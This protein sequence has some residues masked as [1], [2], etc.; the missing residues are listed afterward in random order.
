MPR[1]LLQPADCLYLPLLFIFPTCDNNQVKFL[2]IVLHLSIPPSTVWSIIS[3]FATN[4]AVCPPAFKKSAR[5]GSM[6]AIGRN[7]KLARSDAFFFVF[8]GD[9]FRRFLTG[10]DFGPFGMI[11]LR[12]KG[13]TE[14]IESY[15]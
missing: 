15:R 10:G 7:P 9:V 4:F 3:T 12:K 1:G 6:I 2:T 5:R 11:G 14:E 13:R 8:E